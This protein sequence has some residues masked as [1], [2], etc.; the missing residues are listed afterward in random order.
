MVIP[1]LPKAGVGMKLLSLAGLQ[2]LTA[3]YPYLYFVFSSFTASG[4]LDENRSSM[5]V[6]TWPFVPV[7]ML[8]SRSREMALSA[9]L[10]GLGVTATCPPLVLLLAQPA[11]SRRAATSPTR[12]RNDAFMVLY[13]P[14]GL[15]YMVC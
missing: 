12:A 5:F 8:S 10:R 9:E 2:L 1:P 11:V 7:V 4:V 3:P 14:Q 13:L 15:I 6:L